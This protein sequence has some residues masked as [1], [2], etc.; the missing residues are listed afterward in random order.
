MSFIDTR[1]NPGLVAPLPRRQR[2]TGL[3]HQVPVIQET[4]GAEWEYFGSQTVPLQCES[5]PHIAAPSCAWPSPDAKV[6]ER[7]PDPIIA[8]PYYIWRGTTC[9]AHTDLDLRGRA[10]DTLDAFREQDVEYALWNG[11]PDVEEDPGRMLPGF[12]GGEG[13]EMIGPEEGCSPTG[14]MGTLMQA[15]AGCGGQLIHAPLI[16]LPY[17]VQRG[18]V[19][20]T[21][22]SM[23]TIDGSFEVIFGHGYT[24]VGPTGDDPPAGY[25]WMVGTGPIRVRLSPVR[26]LG[27]DG[28]GVNRSKNTQT[29][30]AEQSVL[31]EVDTCCKF[32]ILVHL[33]TD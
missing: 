31:V 22:D 26:V 25:A 14:A 2:T 30:V 29:V 11:V 32:W 21:G 1:T 16:L 20:R 12:F 23:H 3:L 18:L 24:G 4:A 8:L 5:D 6:P 28:T 15:L 7:Q 27:D 9:E 19:V 10:M 17:L 13:V 33:T